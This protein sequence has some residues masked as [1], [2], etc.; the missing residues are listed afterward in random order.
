MKI[1]S[2]GEYA[3]RA[4][5]ILGQNPNEWL[6]ISELSQKTLV[7]E[8]YL[9]KIML[10]L[11]KLNYVESRRGQH[12]G[13]RLMHTPEQVNLGEIIRRLEGPLAPMGCASLTKYEPCELEAGCLLKPLWILIREVIAQVLEQT[14]LQNL[15][16]G[17]FNLQIKD[18][19]TT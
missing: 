11:K 3:L 2:R 12:G 13:F 10:Q 7:T 8:M 5:I 4:L 16:D 19:E 9:E 15:L 14:T 6:A 18:V 17:Q 1:S